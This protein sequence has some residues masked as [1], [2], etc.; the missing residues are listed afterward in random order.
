M[1]AFTKMSDKGQVV[2]PAGMRHRLGWLPGTDLE[3]IEHG[4]SVTL[5]PRPA[6]KLLTPAQA[7]ERFRALYQHQGPPAT[8]ED[9][10][11]SAR[12]VAA[13]DDSIDP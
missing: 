10:K 6:P 13:G 3:V 8:I 5:R 7:V 1:N 11:A 4:D 9:M 2:V 12:R